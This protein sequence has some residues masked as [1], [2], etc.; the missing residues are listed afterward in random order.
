MNGVVTNQVVT[1]DFSAQEP[2][3]SSNDIS[4]TAALTQCFSEQKSYFQKNTYPSYQQRIDDLRKLKRVL[5]DNEHA[6]IEAMSKDF[7]HR[8]VDDSKLGDILGTVM[9]I[10]YTI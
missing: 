9:G 1:E 4:T 7:G 6:F 2:H 5:I 10:N 3:S 8:S